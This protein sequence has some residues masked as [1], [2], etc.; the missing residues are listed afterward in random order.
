MEEEEQ[1]D[2]QEAEEEV[3]IIE[4]ME[5]EQE[6]EEEVDIV[7]AREGDNMEKSGTS[8][9]CFTLGLQSSNNSDNEEKGP[10]NEVDDT[11]HLRPSSTSRRKA[12][13]RRKSVIKV[14]GGNLI[15]K[16]LGRASSARNG[17]SRRS[18]LRGPIAR[19]PIA[20]LNA[21][22]KNKRKVEAAFQSRA[23]QVARFQKATPLRFRT[24]PLNSDSSEQ[25]KSHKERLHQAQPRSSSLQHLTR[26]GN[27]R[28]GV[29]SR[30][31]LPV[32]E[33][34]PFQLE[35]SKR[36]DQRAA[37][38]QEGVLKAQE[39]ERE[40]HKFKAKEALV[41]RSAPFAPVLPQKRDLVP[42]V[43]APDLN[44]DRRA[45][46][47][48]EFEAR[49]KERELEA[50]A[51]K[52][53]ERKQKHEEEMQQ[54]AEQRRLTV[55]KARPMPQY[56]RLKVVGSQKKVT[57]AHSPYLLTKKNGRAPKC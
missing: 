20:V 37:A 46:E 48:G 7:E 17:T 57:T 16:S 49:R 50:E 19:G 34:V 33:P 41:L 3:D 9:Q 55:H 56:K 32:T 10:S 12:P 28:G 6:A 39:S 13:S 45:V 52:A 1:E 43:Q 54:I 53:L 29:P 31:Q 24:R 11:I 4:A 5:K 27:A 44:T 40:A 42:V 47:R 8:L 21:Q 14:G 35:G 23:E 15:R 51:A 26:T 38:R 18:S 25:V 36:F 2:E 22:K 30:R